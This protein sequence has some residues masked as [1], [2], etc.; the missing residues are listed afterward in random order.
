MTGQP[1]MQAPAKTMFESARTA[2]R[3]A[4]YYGPG[5]RNGCASRKSRPSGPPFVDCRLEAILFRMKILVGIGLC[6]IAIIVWIESLV[7]ALG[8]FHPT[9]VSLGVL[10]GVVISTEGIALMCLSNQPKRV[11]YFD[12]EQ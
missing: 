3:T 12:N 4:P 10:L 6:L 11:P 2:V 5:D 8:I 9:V 7:G 1:P